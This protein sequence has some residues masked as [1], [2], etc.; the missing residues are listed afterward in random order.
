MEA[1]WV[2]LK[3]Y[4]PMLIRQWWAIAGFLLTLGGLILTFAA[5]LNIP[6]PIW[7]IAL[8]LGLV[9]A[10]FE[11][12]HKTRSR[13]LVKSNPLPYW[14]ATSTMASGGGTWLAVILYGSPGAR[15]LETATYTTLIKAVVQW[16]GSSEQALF[17]RTFTGGVQLRL[18]K[19]MFVSP[20]L[21]VQAG[22]E[23]TT[24]ALEVQRTTGDD[25][26][27]LGWV[28]SHVEDAIRFCLS[29]ASSDWVSRKRRTFRIALSNWPD[30]GLSVEGLLSV[31]RFSDQWPRGYRLLL[32]YQAKPK[33]DPWQIA[34]KFGAAVL[35][36]SGYVGFEEELSRL[37]SADCKKYM[38]VAAA[39]ETAG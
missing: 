21:D 3:S 37:T 23:D 17:R 22:I 11:I 1:R 36:D 5:H 39:A 10:Q 14:A 18:P 19:D 4:V 20:Q 33:T 28:L 8:L 29:D 35:S 24:A 16:F 25:P 12:F 13:T 34:C 32:D 26:I 38:V 30:K 15:S 31:K 27:H 2:S 7:L 9:A 6:R